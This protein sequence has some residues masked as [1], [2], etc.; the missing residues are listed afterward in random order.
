MLQDHDNHCFICNLYQSELVCVYVCIRTR[1]CVCTLHWLVDTTSRCDSS[2]CGVPWE[3]KHNKLVCTC[4]C[5]L[6]DYLMSLIQLTNVINYFRQRYHN[7]R[8]YRSCCQKL[9]R[10]VCVCHNPVVTWHM[11][12]LM[13]AGLYHIAGHTIAAP[14]SSCQRIVNLPEG[15]ENA[16]TLP[17]G[18][19]ERATANLTVVIVQ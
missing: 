5:V 12:S 7:T 14:S 13:Y 11:Y 4:V 1:R 19:R 2:Q 9:C 10:C 6:I 3:C 18:P 8:C 15:T 17:R 16:V